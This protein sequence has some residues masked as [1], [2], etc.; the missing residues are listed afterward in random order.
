[1]A[2]N[3]PVTPTSPSGS[4]P[5]PK[6]FVGLS[7]G[8]DVRARLAVLAERLRA[9]NFPAHF[10]YAEKYHLTLAFLG[11]VDPSLLQAL[12]AVLQTVARQNNPFTLAIDR[13]GAFPSE[14]RPRVVFAGTRRAS[15]ALRTLTTSVRDACTQLGFHFT[16]DAVAHIT[17][18]RIKGGRAHLPLL[19]EFEP[20]AVPVGMLTLFQSLPAGQTTRY[21]QL[22]GV[23]LGT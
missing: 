10:E 9:A 3:E 13:I 22:F 4:A 15:E 12:Q 19:A 23:P 8:P 5:L 18:A 16:E 1:L 11:F 20:I 21:E 7:I 14:R 17:L 2:P 6:L